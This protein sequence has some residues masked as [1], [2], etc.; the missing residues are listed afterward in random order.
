MLL[1]CNI[2]TISTDAL[3]RKSDRLL[4]NTGMD[5]IRDKMDEIHWSSRL[6][7]IIGARGGGKSTLIRTSITTGAKG[8]QGKKITHNPHYVAI[9]LLLILLLILS[10]LVISNLPMTAF[11]WPNTAYNAIFS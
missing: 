7:T 8:D 1:T 9:I 10:F 5:I 11:V 4:A 6:I 3:F 2:F